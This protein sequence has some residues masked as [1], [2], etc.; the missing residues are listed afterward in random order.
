MS[1]FLCVYALMFSLSMYGQQF[2]Y[3][4]SICISDFHG[5]L[6][7][8]KSSSIDV[9][10]TYKK[11]D[12]FEALYY[13]LSNTGLDS[14]AFLVNG[15]YN[16]FKKGFSVFYSYIDNSV[17][18]LSAS[19]LGNTRDLVDAVNAQEPLFINDSAYHITTPGEGILDR[20]ME[21][22]LFRRLA[23]FGKSKFKNSYQNKQRFEFNFY[24]T[25]QIINQV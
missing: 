8:G 4:P 12:D 16:S 18:I 1:R 6:T 5:S 14:K 24:K 13:M 3:N 23:L 20:M 10:E 21:A 19:Y 22:E 2:Q 25:Y 17:G 7:K 15:G 9:I 11:T